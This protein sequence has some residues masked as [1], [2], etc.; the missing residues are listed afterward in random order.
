MA[1]ERHSVA[2]QLSVW[3]LIVLSL[4]LAVW[5][6]ESFA[7]P[8]N[9]ELAS[10][11]P[12]VRWLP[13]FEKGWMA[14]VVSFWKGGRNSDRTREVL[15][16]MSRKTACVSALDCSIEAGREFEALA[17]QCTRRMTHVRMSLSRTKTASKRQIRWITMNRLLRRQQ[18]ASIKS[19]EAK[20]EDMRLQKQDA[21]RIAQTLEGQLT[22]HQTRGD[23]A[24]AKA[25]SMEAALTLAEK[26]A[27][28]TLGLLSQLQAQHGADVSAAS[29]AASEEHNRLREKIVHLETQA[30]LLEGHLVSERAR[31]DAADIKAQTTETAL[32]LEETRVA[33]SLALVEQV[34]SLLGLLVQV[35]QY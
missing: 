29:K 31:A 34:L 14:K 7:K 6:A 20:L 17:T 30:Q 28:E 24:E 25:Q 23:A 19:A 4:A 18:Q 12:R 21:E 5:P 16:P 22:G 1:A 13:H 32:H 11:S 15:L 35:C 2:I 9:A 8:S 26:R 10:S 3:L 33:E 27:G